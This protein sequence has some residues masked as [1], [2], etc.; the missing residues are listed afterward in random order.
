MKVITTMQLMRPIADFSHAAM[1]DG[2]VFVGAMAGTDENTR[3]AGSTPG[4]TDFAA[5][6][7]RIFTNLET[8]LGN[9]GARPEDLLRLKVYLSD[10]RNHA[11]YMEWFSRRFPDADFDHVVVGSDGYPLPQAVIELDAVAAVPGAERP[12]QLASIPVKIRN[13]T[14]ED[15]AGEIQANLTASPSHVAFLG[16]TLAH[17][18]A[19]DALL[20]GIREVF[21]AILPP[22]SV[23]VA[24]LG[25]READAVL[26][27]AVSSDVP[28][29]GPAAEG[30]TCA[31]YAV[32]GDL[33]FLA[34]R[35]DEDVAGGIEAGA[36][37]VLA[38]MEDSFEQ[39]GFPRQS[40]I[41]TYNTLDDWRDYAAFNAAYGTHVSWPF[42]PRTTMLAGLAAGARVQIEGIGYRR[43]DEVTILQVSSKEAPK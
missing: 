42:P 35:S 3:L 34:A 4:A 26:E 6:T 18:S 33:I 40:L 8:V 9:F 37:N 5:Q 23:S 16:V 24:K 15:I 39:A 30:T 17:P 1:A 25:P 12:F 32:V 29:V 20:Q 31:A 2:M 11:P 28:E 27:V 10:M 21:G 7:E 38:L 36:D 19:R 41:R 43:P 13:R 22:L 14:A